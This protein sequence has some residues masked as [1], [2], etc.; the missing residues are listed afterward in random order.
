MTSPS[1]QQP[2]QPEPDLP[3][4]TDRVRMPLLT[5]ITQQALDEDYLVAAE[6]HAAGAPL[7]PRGRPRRTV[8]A[9]VAAFGLL[10]ATA[11]V[12][13]SRNA[14]V[15]QA[16]RATLI[17]RIDAQRDRLAV[18]QD[19]VAGLREDNLDLEKAVGELADT[20]QSSQVRNRRLQV[21]TGFVSVFG[22][23]IRITI[24]E[25]PDADENQQVQD[26]DLSLLVNGLWEAGAEAVAVNDQRVTTRT[27][28]RKSGLAIR[29][30]NVGV[31][32]PYVVVAIGDTRT[33][34]G[35]LFDTASGLA[36]AGT[37]E[38]YG[39]DYDVENVD[40]LTLPTAPATLLRLRSA[41]TDT[42]RGPGTEPDEEAGQ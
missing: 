6:R 4:L 36:F 7:P 2:E 25:K 21:S 41:T 23:G 37:A 30:N 8:A 18:Q 17:E 28:V 35:R 29:V 19:V 26:K 34:S 38:F 5:L 12:Q 16:S 20:E 24:T 10:V 31:A 33:L 27:A 42:G 9:V 32:P 11:F 13:T 1:T 15:D 14:D 22:E 3:E 40:R 39:F